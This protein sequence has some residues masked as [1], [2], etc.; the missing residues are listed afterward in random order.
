MQTYQRYPLAMRH[1]SRRQATIRHDVQM[2][3]GG[4]ALAQAFAAHGLAST[5][6]PGRPAPDMYPDIVVNSENEEQYQA[7]QGYVP[8]GNPSPE[9]F[10]TIQAAPRPPGYQGGEWPKMIDGKVVG[11]PNIKPPS[12]E[13]PKYL[14]ALDMIA[15]SAEHEEALLGAAG[16]DEDDKMA[17]NCQVLPDG[18]L[19][20]ADEALNRGEE[21]KFIIATP[22]PRGRP[23]K[24]A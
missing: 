24:M 6:S 21:P 22:R 18:R 16:L 12:N 9:G 3:N 13:Y 10:A 19:E 20:S 15:D 17:V 5:A 1:P 23:P 4:P 14:P 11:D 8:V 2:A 7:A